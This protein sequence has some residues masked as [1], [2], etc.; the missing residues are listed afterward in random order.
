MAAEPAG[1]VVHESV[2]EQFLGAMPAGAALL[3]E[4][5]VIRHVND[6]LGALSGYPRAELL[7]HEVAD[8]VLPRHLDKHKYRKSSTKSS[9]KLAK[10]DGD[11]LMLIRHSGS[12][13]AV[14]IELLP[15]VL[16]GEPWVVA[17]IRDISAERTM[18]QE[19]NRAQLFFRLAFEENMA[20]TTITDIQSNILAANDAFCKMVG[21]SRAELLGHDASL[22]SQQEDLVMINE[23]PQRM[24]TGSANQ[25]RY[26]KH[27][28]H[29][30][31]RTIFVEVSSTQ[32]VD[33]IDGT[34]FFIVSQR[35]ITEQRR[36]TEQLTFQALHERST[37]L[38]NRS[39][40]DNRLRE[41]RSNVAE[42][43]GLSAVLMLDIDD[44]KGVNNEFGYVVA[45]QLIEQV[46]QRLLTATGPS[47]DLCRFRA[48]KFFYLAEKLES[49]D[50]AQVIADRLLA[51]FDDPFFVDR[52]QIIMTASVGVLT[53]GPTK[54]TI[55]EF[56]ELAHIA[57]AEAKHQGKNRYVVFRE[58]MRNERTA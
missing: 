44:F 9:A 36:L 40:I 14:S 20:P 54:A 34:V 28:Q 58:A 48:D 33:E 35:D 12:D 31:G 13:L 42:D 55:A 47:D 16:D 43:S 19:R 51:T 41:M 50:D 52:K 11:E 39:F 18:A 4:H 23:A 56:I 8:F 17:T 3:D 30:N 46:A 25:E 21:Y 53:F 57:V 26:L 49:A 15:L 27:Y 10:E 45:D 29:R 2:W 7:G 22:F 37:G 38:P 32:A 24:N 5:G 6:F 1:V